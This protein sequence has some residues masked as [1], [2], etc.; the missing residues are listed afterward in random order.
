[1]VRV[2]NVYILPG[3]PRLFEAM[4]GANK[5]RFQGP[6]IVLTTL[7]TRQGEG[8]IG[9]ALRAIATAHPAV[10]IGSYPR[11]TDEQNYTTKLCFEGRDEAD[12]V[13]AVQAAR[14]AVELYEEA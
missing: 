5:D 10:Q 4:V 13:A 1:M 3:I 11:T 2:E 7:F 6:S 14:A 12:V 9:E 8:D